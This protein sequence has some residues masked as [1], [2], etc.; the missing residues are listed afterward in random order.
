MKEYLRCGRM[1]AHFLRR[2]WRPVARNTN[3]S[4]E[5]VFI[6]GCSKE[7]MDAAFDLSEIEPFVSDTDIVGD[8]IFR[9]RK[10]LEK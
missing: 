7:R 10:R 6:N 4:P 8:E 9:D 3:F 5:L 2:W 1:L